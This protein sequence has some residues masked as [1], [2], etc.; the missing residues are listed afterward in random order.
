MLLANE[1]PEAALPERIVRAVRGIISDDKAALHEPEF[2]GNEWAYVKDCIDTGWVSSVGAYVDRFERQIIELTGARHAVAAVNGTAALHVSL[3]LVGVRPGDEVLVPALTFIAT[4]NAVTY[5]GATPHFVDSDPR[6]LGVDPV[7]LDAHLRE[8]A[9]L[10]HGHCINRR[11]GAV[12]RAL[13]PMHTFGHPVDLDALVALAERWN[14]ALVEDA[15][16]A[17]GSSY[18]GRA[19]GRFGRIAAFSFNG[20]KLVTTGGG[21]AIVTDDPELGQLAKHL[22][23]TARVPHRWSFIH[24]RIGFNYRLPN[25]NAALGC[26]QLER[27]PDMLTRKRALAQRYITAF[28][29]LHGASIVEQPSD[30]ESN[31]WLVTLKLDAA[32]E[33]ARDAVLDAL[34]ADGLM[35]RP[36][37]TLMH[38]LP[39]FASCPRMAVPQAETLELQLINLPSSPKLA[40]RK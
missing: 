1:L 33:A 12:I 40:D 32:D 18:K 8:I 17:L 11:T 21:G 19:C 31:Y 14:L 3:L 25:I 6:T 35:A 7:A 2:A 26:A 5:A 37:W 38:K 24:D 30:S 4:A 9:E 34:N 16:E 28:D 22:T 10:R 29:N 13:M 27:L 20:N 23:T 15:A 39:M 36:V